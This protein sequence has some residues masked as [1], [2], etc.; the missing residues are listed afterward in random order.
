MNRDAL[1]DLLPAS[2]AFL[3]SFAF[4]HGPWFVTAGALLPIIFYILYL[5]NIQPSSGIYVCSSQSNG[6]FWTSMY[7]YAHP[8]IMPRPLYLLLSLA[9][10]VI[11]CCLILIYPV[12]F[13]FI[14]W[15]KVAW[16]MG[17]SDLAR[18]SSSSNPNAQTRAKTKLPHLPVM[19]AEILRKTPKTPKTPNAKPK[20][21]T[22]RKASQE[23]FPGAMEMKRDFSRIEYNHSELLKIQ[24][25][26]N[27]VLAQIFGDSKMTRDR[28]QTGIDQAVE[29]SEKNLEAAQAYMETGK[30]PEIMK[31]YLEKSE[32]INTK[33]S[34]LLDAIAAHRNDQM[35]DSFKRLNDNL[36]ELEQSVHY[37]H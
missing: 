16:K 34:K 11:G 19:E 18:V 6:K 13:Y 23:L 2:L 3:I 27:R 17:T 29:L 33:T 10:L 26:A 32:Q 8:V 31:K 28:F 20:K 36:E 5:L 25:S 35:D 37:Y 15:A 30:N 14:N 24:T 1:R 4:I 21:E 22:R 9:Y 7:D 12:A